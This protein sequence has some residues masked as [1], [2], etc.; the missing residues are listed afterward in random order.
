MRLDGDNDLKPVDRLRLEEILDMCADYEKQIGQKADSVVE[1][2]GM[3]GMAAMQSKTSPDNNGTKRSN[4]SN[5]YSSQSSHLFYPSSPTHTLQLSPGGSLLM[6]NR[7][8][9]LLHIQYLFE[10]RELGDLTKLDVK[11]SKV[12]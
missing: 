7:F 12:I 2:D 8:L 6:P 11:C 1:E 3:N 9:F 4:L 5:L 10:S